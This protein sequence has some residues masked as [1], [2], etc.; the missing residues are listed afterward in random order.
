MS[1]TQTTGVVGP[2]KKYTVA[3]MMIHIEKPTIK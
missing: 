3:Q 2:P 1:Q